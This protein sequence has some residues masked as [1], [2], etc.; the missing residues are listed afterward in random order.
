[1][2]LKLSA[3]EVV[4]YYKCY[5]VLSDML[6]ILGLGMIKDRART[7]SQAPCCES[8]LFVAARAFW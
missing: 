7:G 4:K 1:M 6:K 8:P 3:L 5:L 2:G